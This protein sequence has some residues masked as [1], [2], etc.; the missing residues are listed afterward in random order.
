MDVTL[1]RVLNAWCRIKSNWVKIALIVVTA[2]LLAIIFTAVYGYLNFVRTFPVL[3]RR[4]I[5]QLEADAEQ[6]SGLLTTA[7]IKHALLFG[8]ALGIARYGTLLPWDD[9]IDFGIHE[10][11]TSLLRTQILPK[12]PAWK[13]MVFGYKIWL[14]KDMPTPVDIY[15]LEDHC[16]S[17]TLRCPNYLYYDYV[18]RQCD[19]ANVERREFGICGG[20][21]RSAFVLSNLEGSLTWYFGGSWRSMAVVKR[22]HTWSLIKWCYS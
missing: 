15:L 13:K 2:A 5:E 1:D 18:V 4:Q 12:V 17:K 19:W 10:S 11:D 21:R 16:P 9:D 22:P 6:M 20:P 8:G 7:G 3:T 14:R